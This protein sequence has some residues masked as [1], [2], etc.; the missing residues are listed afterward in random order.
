MLNMTKM[1]VKLI[2]DRDMYVFFEKDM[3]GGASYISN[4]YSEAN[5]K[6]LKSYD[7]KQ[8]PKHIIYLNTNNLT[9]MQ[10]LSFFQQ[11]ALTGLIQKSLTWINILAI[12]QKDVLSKL[13]LNITYFPLSFL[14]KKSMKFIMKTCNFTED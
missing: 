11:A 14:T 8:E 12:V 10:S 1:K 6:Y 9:V 5:N 7:P 3:T 2:A 13:I 4:W